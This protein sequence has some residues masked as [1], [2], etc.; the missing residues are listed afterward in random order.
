MIQVLKILKTFSKITSK[1]IFNLF[2]FI[3]KRN[4]HIFILTLPHLASHVFTRL[5]IY[6][7]LF[8][9]SSNHHLSF[10]K[11]FLTIHVEFDEL[12]YKLE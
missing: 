11:A 2:I 6:L 3:I 5:P 1:R 4:Y 8:L 7:D 10:S 12:S 9:L